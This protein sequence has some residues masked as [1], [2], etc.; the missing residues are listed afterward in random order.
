LRILAET[1]GWKNIFKKLISFF[2]FL[3][4]IHVS[5]FVIVVFL[6]REDIIG[7][8]SFD[9]RVSNV[10]II[11]SVVIF[12]Q[13]D[14]EMFSFKKHSICKRFEISHLVRSPTIF[15]LEIEYFKSDLY[16]IVLIY[17]FCSE[18]FFSGLRF[19]TLPIMASEI[20]HHLTAVSFASL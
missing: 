15:F 13:L 16:K 3:N 14:Q 6:R 11:S 17:L 2:V 18:L 10:F 8:I 20:L 7:L 9:L 19:G 4:K 12:S 1:I 5:V